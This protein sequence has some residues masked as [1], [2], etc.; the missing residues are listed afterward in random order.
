M[1]FVVDPVGGWEEGGGPAGK[2]LGERSGDLGPEELAG[3]GAEEVGQLGG[4]G[5]QVVELVSAEGVGHE[6]GGG[7]GEGVKGL[8]IEEE[9]ESGVAAGH[10][11]A[12]RGD[13]ARAE[14]VEGPLPEDDLVV[15]GWL[16]GAGGDEDVGDAPLAARV[17]SRVEVGVGS[18]D[19]GERREEVDGD[20]VVGDDASGAAVDAGPADEAGDADAAL[21]QAALVAAVRG[22]EADLGPAAGR[23]VELGRRLGG[24]RAV[25]GGDDEKGVVGDAPGVEEGEEV[26]D[27]DVEGVD[28]G[29]VDALDALRGLPVSPVF[30]REEL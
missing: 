29:S 1:V 5:G 30:S 18:G 19:A 22:G 23:V 14:H 21:V 17:G 9:F 25:V 10:G 28:G 15:L 4:V 16:L 6:L 2:I 20:D 8:E 24:L 12:G 3:R 26:A 13:V 11:E 27:E 7:A